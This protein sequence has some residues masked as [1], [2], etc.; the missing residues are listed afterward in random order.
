LKKVGRKKIQRRARLRDRR[1]SLS[2]EV[3]REQASVYKITVFYQGQRLEN[4]FEL[5]Y[6]RIPKKLKRKN[7]TF[8]GLFL[9]V[10]FFAF[11]K[12]LKIFFTTAKKAAGEINLQRKN[13][14][15]SAA[16]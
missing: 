3:Q 10:K 6:V 11:F 4:L 5:H 2:S 13:Y 1:R 9:F 8:F 15:K 16:F 12:I 7:I 14:K